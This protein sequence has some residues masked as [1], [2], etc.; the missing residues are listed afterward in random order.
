MAGFF[1]KLLIFL[2]VATGTM[3]LVLKLLFKNTILFKLALFWGISIIF[4]VLN[5][6]LTGAFPDKYPQPISL[7]IGVIAV[8][9]LVAM[10][11]RQIRRPLNNIL[12]ALE[13]L[14]H[15]DLRVDVDESFS[16]RKDELGIIVRS[17][18]KISS[19]FQR[20]I[21]QLNASAEKI[22]QAGNQLTLTS[23]QLSSGANQQAA[24]VEELS[25]T[26][27]E[28]ASNIQNN[29]TNA[30]ETEKIAIHANAGVNEV[31]EAE[32][33]SFSSI[34]NIAEK[35]GI[36]TDIA[37][38][39]NLLAL[40]AAVEAAR[41]GEQGKGFA[42][43]AAEVRKL[44]ERSRQAADEI[45][46]LADESVKNSK[47]AGEKLDKIAPEISRTTQLVQEIAASSSE[48]NHGAEQVNNAIQGLNSVT[49]QNSNSA[50]NMS[51]NA[52]DLAEQA[53][54]LLELISYFKTD[55]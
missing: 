41:A 49:Q 37:F 32:K 19:S 54:Q 40:N 28:I 34:N 24:T 10:A 35:I 22:S 14:S 36:I 45:V 20:T 48:Q 52:E 9:F 31:N 44:A 12:N 4:T 18:K 15:G 55:N 11:S 51:K 8:V 13:T 17:I 29:S 7:P 3:V 42:V 23:N 1:L 38:Q 43:V 27:E 53:Q 5:T 2:A 16:R 25:S 30:A 39:T 33:V 26:M 46:K 21:G 47:N 50:D 6:K